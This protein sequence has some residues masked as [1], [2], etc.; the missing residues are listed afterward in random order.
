MK[1]SMGQGLGGRVKAT[2]PYGDSMAPFVTVSVVGVDRRD[3]PA[4]KDA[5]GACVAVG[6]CIR[7]G[8]T[9]RCGGGFTAGL[10]PLLN[11]Y[12]EKRTV[13]FYTEH[14]T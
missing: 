3:R 9:F 4:P 13:H 6:S 12:G 14:H 1:K 8:R 5:R 11:P 7:Y 10:R 2:R